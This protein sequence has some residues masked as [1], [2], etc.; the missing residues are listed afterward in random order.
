[1]DSLDLARDAL[2]LT[3]KLS[4]PILIAALLV[5]VIISLF[6]ALTQIQDQTLAFVPKLITVL[7]V[8]F[9]LLPYMGKTLLQFN[10]NLSNQ[11]V[12]IR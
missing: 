10:E 12:K 1:M 7:L 11:I 9:F 2:I 8:L 3:L 6:Q 5:G 4:M